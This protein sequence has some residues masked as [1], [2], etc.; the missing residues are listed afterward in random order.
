MIP[1]WTLRTLLYSGGATLTF[2]EGTQW[3]CPSILFRLPGP[4]LL[5]FQHHCPCPTSP[6]ASGG[7]EPLPQ[8][9]S[10][11][12]ACD[13]IPP[14]EMW[15]KTC[16]AGLLA[17]VSRTEPGRKLPVNFAGGRQAAPSCFA[18]RR[19]PW[20][21]CFEAHRARSW[22]VPA[23][24]LELPPITHLEVSTSAL[25][26]MW[27]N[28]ASF[29][30]FSV[31]TRTQKPPWVIHSHFID[32]RSNF[33]AGKRLSLIYCRDYF[34]CSDRNLTQTAWEQKKEFIDSSTFRVPE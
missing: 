16:W 33:G 6:L 2:L 14:N 30:Q 12:G 29:N 23:P 32:E 17:Q 10:P 28:I 27:D 20:G 11:E 26:G 3:C 8:L 25:P 24:G 5:R 4:I 15:G 31:K 19:K 1:L 13:S 7:A 34:G 21:R 9:L 22:K 18:L